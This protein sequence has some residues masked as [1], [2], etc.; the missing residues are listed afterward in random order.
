[1]FIRLHTDQVQRFWNL[2]V[3]M[4]E[5]SVPP[6]AEGGM[7]RANKVCAEVYKGNADVWI[8]AERKDGE[9]VTHAMVLTTITWDRLSGVKNLLVY[10]VY[11]WGDPSGFLNAK[12]KEAVETL[13]KY[14]KKHG[15]NRIVAY[16]NDLKV[17]E[18]AKA[19]GGKEICRLI[20]FEIGE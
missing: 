20:S 16:T 11:S 5:N 2:L 14:G 3:T 15:C 6:I 19:F 7:N 10:G 17:L 12:W 13:W 9:V 4:V 8:S 1:M 18:R